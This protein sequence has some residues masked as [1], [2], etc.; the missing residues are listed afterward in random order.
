MPSLDSSSIDKT[1]LGARMEPETVGFYVGALIINAFAA[2][3]TLRY[4]HARLKLEERK[5]AIEEKKL[6]AAIEKAKEANP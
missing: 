2:F 5:I 3:F 4:Y 1:Y 6:G